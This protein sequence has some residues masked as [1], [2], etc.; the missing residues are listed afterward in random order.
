MGLPRS[1]QLPQFA[2]SAAATAAIQE[3]ARTIPHI[4]LQWGPDLRVD[5]LT[6]ELAVM[7]APFHETLVGAKGG[8][9]EE[10]GYF[11]GVAELSGG[12]WQFRNAHW[13]VAGYARQ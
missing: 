13:S 7:A 10:S 2:N 3:L 1:G 5:P 12:R 9:V 11:T 8:R 4:E 6:P